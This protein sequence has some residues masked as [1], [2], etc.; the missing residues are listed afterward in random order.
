M[1]ELHHLGLERLH[2]LP[3]QNRIPVIVQEGS[4]PVEVG[5]RDGVGGRFGGVHAGFEVQEEGAV[6]AGGEEGG[7]VGVVEEGDL[8]FCYKAER[9]KA[10][11]GLRLEGRMLF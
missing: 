11:S 2:R 7:G 5:R 9:D 6:G 3:R 8:G 10:V 1:R 4:E